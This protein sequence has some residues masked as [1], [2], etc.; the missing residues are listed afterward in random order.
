MGILVLYSPAS[1]L[2][3]ATDFLFRGRVSVPWRPCTQQPYCIWRGQLP[4]VSTNDK[5]LA[6]CRLNYAK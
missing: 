1:F 2:F 5:H 6:L 3:L 4:R